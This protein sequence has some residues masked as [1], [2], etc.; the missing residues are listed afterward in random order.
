MPAG[1]TFFLTGAGDALG[2]IGGFF[3]GP[4]G[5]PQRIRHIASRVDALN[6]EYQGHVRVL[7]EAV[8][9]LT[10]SWTGDAARSFHTAWYGPETCEARPTS[11]VQVMA[12][13]AS[14]M[15]TFAGQ[16]RDYADSLERAQHEHWIELGVMAAMTLVNVAQLGADPVTDAAEIGI[17][18]GS[19]ISF[20]SVAEIATTGAM[21][22][23]TADVVGQLGADA[24]DG[25][26]PGFDRSGGDGVPVFDVGEAVSSGLSGAVSGLVPLGLGSLGSGLGGLM[27]QPLAR[28]VAG[29]VAASG[30]DAGFQWA[31]TGEVD[32]TEVAITGGLSGAWG[33]RGPS[34]VTGSV[35]PIAG[36]RS[37]LVSA[38]KAS[39]ILFGDA[40]GGGHLWPGRAGKT[41][42]PRSWSPDHVLEVISDIATDPSAL[43]VSQ[44]GGRTVLLGARA[45]V[46]II[47]VTDGRDIITGYP[48]NLPR[49]S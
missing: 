13:V 17:A 33:L 12:W 36:S 31:T 18:S 35:A 39:H 9:L 47:V 44:V 43:I 29:G 22:N 6:A 4:P 26:D 25:L 8:D 5:D 21:A 11:P 30:A 41:P 19:A 49:N 14:A 2:D 32:W 27:G 48:V 46:T 45:G 7:S 34:E 24:W 16:L 20:G 42:F 40:T 38:A 28:A 3:T 1:S 23:L 15:T 10:T 37:N